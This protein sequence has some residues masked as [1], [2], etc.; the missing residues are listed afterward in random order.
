MLMRKS[1]NF[2]KTKYLVVLG[3]ILIL[4]VSYILTDNLVNTLI[5]TELTPLKIFKFSINL[6]SK[7]ILKTVF[8]IT[9]FGFLS[10]VSY[11]F[12]NLIQIIL[13]KINNKTGDLKENKYYSRILN[14]YT[15]GV[16]TYLINQT[17]VEE[18]LISTVM[19]LESKRYISIKED[20][21]KIIRNNT[22]GLSQNEKYIF[23][24]I[25]NKNIKKINY[26]EFQNKIIEDSLKEK[27][28]EECNCFLR[29]I[30]FILLLFVPIILL[31]TISP[32][33]T[34]VEINLFNP[35]N[36]NL[37][38]YLLVNIISDVLGIIHIFLITGLIY[39]LYL[40]TD[41]KYKL[42]NKGQEIVL[43]LNTLKRELINNENEYIKWDEYPIYKTIFAIDKNNIREI[44]K[45]MKGEKR[46]KKR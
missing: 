40:K 24:N 38:I 22:M 27:L 28:I 30:Y 13:N 29:K 37:L 7:I 15:P 41:S 36:D 34:L 10:L 11:L 1:L 6:K 35:K 16:L 18:T 8:T 9:Y 19:F 4:F 31:L 17:I 32:V 23:N 42:T 46:E 39:Y 26:R 33:G 43:E 14:K 44:F 3:L 20:K 45:K 12:I 2:K 5:I 21:F 25:K